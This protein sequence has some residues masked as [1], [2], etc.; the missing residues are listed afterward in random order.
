M[1]S[2]PHGIQST[3]SSLGHPLGARDDH[4]QGPTGTTPPAQQPR[5]GAPA[6]RA[7]PTRAPRCCR[8][9]GAVATRESGTSSEGS[10]H[11]T[12]LISPSAAHHAH[13]ASVSAAHHG[14]QPGPRSSLSP[15]VASAAW[16]ALVVPA[17]RSSPCHGPQPAAKR[18]EE[19]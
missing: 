1:C 3:C 17:A 10:W 7:P 14:R 4:D 15:L 9:S 13:R 19:G 2:P 12:G 6:R 18:E 5:A 8:R 16:G 11:G